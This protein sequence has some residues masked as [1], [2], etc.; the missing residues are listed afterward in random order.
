MRA[1]VSHYSRRFKSSLFACPLSSLTAKL[2]EADAHLDIEI[3]P[4]KSS[5]E[6][7][8]FRDLSAAIPHKFCHDTITIHE[9]DD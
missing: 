9:A 6:Y 8:N 5:P 7:Y 4:P 1:R 3:A 2:P